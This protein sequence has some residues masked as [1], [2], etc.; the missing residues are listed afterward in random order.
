MDRE[1]WVQRILELLDTPSYESLLNQALDNIPSEIDKRQGSIVHMIL[2]AIC[3]EIDDIQMQSTKMHLGSNPVTAT[4]ED[5]DRESE[6]Y[7][8]ERKKATKSE[9]IIRVTP[10]LD[11]I[12][13]GTRFVSQY[14]EEP[15]TYEIVKRVVYEDN[16]PE[17]VSKSFYRVRAEE[18]G[19]IGNT[20]IG[21]LLPLVNIRNLET[22]N[23]LTI[24][25]VGTDIETDEELRERV[26]NKMTLTAFAGN[27]AYYRQIISDYDYIGGLQVYPAWQGGGTVKL[28]V[29]DKSKKPLAENILK[30]LREEIDP[31]NYSGKGLGLAP[32]GSKVTITSPE[33]KPIDISCNIKFL[34]STANPVEIDAK[35][36]NALESYI[37]EL[38]AK[39]SSPD[40]YN[41]YRVTVVHSAVS[42][43]IQGIEG[44]ESVTNL[45]ING[46]A[47]DVELKQ[48]STLQE[49]PQLGKFT[50]L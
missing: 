1:Y 17:I 30:N 18:V 5:L 35:I 29:I 32:I 11:N 2:S 6:I 20:Y 27:V 46:V 49:F 34:S 48:N 42:S 3:M 21:E 25:I 38:Q 13:V 26:G 16:D 37:L 45:T 23:L 31:I 14:T 36:Q 40:E 24:D 4:G 33:I 50:R 44:V 41:N 7:G 15:I 8:I 28:V 47:R 10:Q 9:G 12:P 43:K 22:V 19:D 39:W